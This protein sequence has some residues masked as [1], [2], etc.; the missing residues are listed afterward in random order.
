MNQEFEAVFIEKARAAFL[1]S[2][3]AVDA[4]L[5]VR[6][7]A[8]RAQAVAVA[9][10]HLPRRRVRSW[11]LPAGAA[12]VL[13]AVAVGGFV[14]WT[15]V[16]QPAVPFAVNNND[17]VNIVLTNDNLD[18]YADLD[19]YRWLE[20]QQQPRGVQDGAGGNNNG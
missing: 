3:V 18:M 13:C 8:A 4:R 19:F 14:W 1:G 2:T 5:L 15:Q 12:A 10:Q 7:R 16:S 6:L 11:A 17:D 20:A 9:E